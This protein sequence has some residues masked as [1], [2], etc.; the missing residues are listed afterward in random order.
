[1]ACPPTAKYVREF[2]PDGYRGMT[3]PA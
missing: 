1:M 3:Q 2:M